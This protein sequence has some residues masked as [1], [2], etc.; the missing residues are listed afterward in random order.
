MASVTIDGKEYDVDS[1]SDEAKKQ[2]GSLQFVQG[3]INKLNAQIAVCRTAAVAYTAALKK[4]IDG[5]ENG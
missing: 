4:E 5:N 3:E 1:L 2:L